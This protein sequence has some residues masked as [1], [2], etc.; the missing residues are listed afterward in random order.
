MKKIED[1]CDYSDMSFPTSYDEIYKFEERNN[2]CLY[3]YEL[4]EDGK[5]HLE[6]PGKTTIAR[7]EG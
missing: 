6:K 4:D 2:V 5:V 3:V 7:R 1:K